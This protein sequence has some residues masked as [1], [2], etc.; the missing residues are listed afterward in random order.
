M[1]A[2]SSILICLLV[3]QKMSEETSVPQLRG[4]VGLEQFLLLAK[5]AKGAA[6][7]QLVQEATS[8]PGLY[9]FGELLEMDTIQALNES[10]HAPLLRLLEVFTYG[11]Y[12]DYKGE[13]ERASY[14][15]AL[16]WYIC[17][18]L[19]CH[20]FPHTANISVLPQLCPAQLTKLKHLTIITLAA[21]FRVCVCVCTHMCGCGMC[22]CTD[23]HTHV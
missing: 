14:T 2:K 20:C 5:S 18:R 9:V 12:T 11:T 8:T 23:A 16:S 10:E 21:K 22:M 1:Y 4:D 17:M 13:T 7:A 19:V 6:A 3:S 15:C